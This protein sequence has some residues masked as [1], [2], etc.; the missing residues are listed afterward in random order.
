MP[1]MAAPKTPEIAVPGIERIEPPPSTDVPARHVGHVLEEKMS[2]RGDGPA[3]RYKAGT[4]WRDISWRELSEQVRALSSAL[5]AAGIGEGDRVA[6]L[7]PNQPSWTVADLA[8]LRVRA[9]SVPIHA[10]SSGAQ[11]GFI[12]RDSG[13]RLVFAGAGEAAAKVGAVLGDCPA[14]DRVVVLGE[15][16]AGDPRF[17]GL[18]AMLD[19]G[20][21]AG[22]DG[23]VADRLGRAQPSDL[24]TLLYTSGTTGEPKGVM[25]PHSAFTVTCAYHDLRLP[26]IGTEDVS[27]CFLP[28]SHIFERAWTFYVLY[29][30][31]V[32]AYCEDPK[33][34]AELLPEVRPT[35]MCAVPRLYEKVYARVREKANAASPLRRALFRWSVETGHAVSV[36]RRAGREVP[37]TLALRHAVADRLVLSKVRAGFGGRPRLFPCAGAPLSPEIEEFFHAVGIFV[38]QGYGLTETTAT[39]TCHDPARFHVGTVGTPLPGIEVR[40]S[41]EGEVLVRGRTLM[42]GYWNRPE[43]SAAVLRDGWLRT[44]DAGEICEDGTLRITDRIK[45]LIKTSG[46]KYVAPQHVETTIGAD[47]LVEQV[48]V[49]GEGRSYVTALVV[50]AFEA[51]EK[52]AR[53]AGVSFAG[54]EELVRDERVLDLMRRT[55][56]ERTKD[57]APWEKVRRFV[58]LPREFSVEGGSMTPT[59]KVRRRAAADLYR[60]DI[61][62]MYADD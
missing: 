20:R 10:T 51:L 61:E 30:G 5:V 42:L 28:L 12:L 14:V 26:P 47:P 62:K 1:S 21:S 8:I 34:I 40:I 49:V 35:L 22:R 46:G 13:A 52:W 55:I 19:A 6:I 53:A 23:D 41:E 38:C 32:N 56:D 3:L 4:S 43:E 48:A 58:L 37:A 50:P 15:P 17:T 9:I 27:L 16:P 25:L 44:G 24:L 29:R 36:R 11:V 18:D 45:D 57:L 60:D 2:T 39:V 7:A 33:S 59:L 54:R 31:A